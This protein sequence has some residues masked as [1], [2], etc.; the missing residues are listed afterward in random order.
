MYRLLL[1]VFLGLRCQIEAFNISPQPIKTFL[2]PNSSKT[3]HGRSSYFGYSLVIREKS[4]IVAAPRANSTLPDQSKV[5]EPGAI[6]R[7]L[8]NDGS[9]TSY[10]VD[11]KG[12]HYEKASTD[13]LRAKGK[14]FQW[15]G[16]SMDGGTLDSDRFLVCAP[17]F[18]SAQEVT[19]DGW[20][21]DSNTTTAANISM[22]GICY[23]LKNTT[24]EEPDVTDI[25]PFA[26]RNKQTETI[27]ENSKPFYQMGQLGLSAHVSKASTLVMGAPG[28][29]M[30]R[31][32]V[33]L[34]PENQV[35]GG[36]RMVRDTSRAHHRY[37]RHVSQPNWNQEEDSYFGYSV[38]SGYF[39]SSNPNKLLYVATAPHANTKSGEAYIFEYQ[40]EGRT[41]Q[42]HT[43]FHGMQF[44]EY[45]GYSVLVED[46]NG[47]RKPDLI[48]SA[49]Q[50]ALEDSYDN[51]AIYVFT[52]KGSFHFDLTIIHSPVGN[53]G[54]FGTTL[55]QL[56]DIN[57]DGYNGGLL[58]HLY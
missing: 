4:I 11:T 46:L 21:Y 33:Y 9:C 17:R 19:H 26:L 10:D 18:Y 31:G 14:D 8:F 47:D 5:I 55:S 3:E 51:G 40:N 12:N 29:D 43:K 27:G 48:I 25:C 34:N 58:T 57:Q 36:G 53:K 44:G 22:I 28:I 2:Y 1:L 42:N 6:F 54:R 49:P 56:G 35:P 38:S 30:F 7:C 15:M 37:R 41:M 20:K 50:H 52:N 39:D 45:F 23:W 13:V 32:S 16:G 24:E